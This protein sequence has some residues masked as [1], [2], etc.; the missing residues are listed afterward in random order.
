MS[1]TF[2]TADECV[3]R[4]PDGATILVGGFGLCGQ[5]YELIKALQRAGTRDLT[6]IS[7]NIGEPGRGLGILVRSGQIAKAVSSFFSTN[8]EVLAAHDRGEMEL[9]LI[10]Q[11]TLAE[12][13]RAGGAGIPAFYTPTAAG[14]RLADGHEVTMFDGKECVLQRS[15]TADFALIYARNADQYGNLSYFK[16]ERNFN[17]LM[18]TAGGT[19]IAEVEHVV[20]SFSS[21]ELVA[22]PSLFIDVMV[23]KTLENGLDPVQG[24][25]Q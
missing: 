6:I 9:E 25:A 12:A 11:G 19:V 14:T 21:P 8:K 20:D 3:S 18:A 5:P 23:R 10:P 2:E 13:I 16:T 7:N 1:V 17:P 4:I 15:I 24:E 22:T